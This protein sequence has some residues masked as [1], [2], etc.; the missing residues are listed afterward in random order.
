MT[1]TLNITTT[2]IQLSE[3]VNQVFSRETRVIIQKSGIPVAAIV[4]AEDAARLEE[5]E[6]QRSEDFSY[7]ADIQHKFADVPLEE[8]EQEVARAVR[9]ARS[10]LRTTDRELG[11]SD[12]A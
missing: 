6:R 5:Y 12:P 9:Q 2:R 10:R 8:H 4:S 3:L 11:A 1:Q 7:L